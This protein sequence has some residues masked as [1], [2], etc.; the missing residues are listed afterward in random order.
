MKIH[1]FQG[2][3]DQNFTYLVYEQKLES[4]DYIGI[5]IDPAV[6]AQEILQFAEKNN[7]KI[8]FV[9]IMH[10]HFDHLVDLDIYLKKG[11]SIYAH[12]SIHKEIASKITKKIN[13]NEII[14]L[15]KLKFKVI[16]TPGHEKDCICL[17]LENSGNKS[18]PSYLFTSDTLFI[19][20]YG[21]VD[22]PGSNV[23]EMADSLEHIKQLPDDTIIMPGHDY[24]D[25]KQSTLGEEKEKNTFMKVSKKEFIE[26]YD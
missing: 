9:V 17:L 12:K 11:I 8:L 19:G 23:T 21:R 16:Y 4:Q 3:Y 5:I 22:L 1:T 7:I 20:S 24:G 25:K 6:S 13:N 2:G 18:L 14:N 15:D 10:S 26:Y